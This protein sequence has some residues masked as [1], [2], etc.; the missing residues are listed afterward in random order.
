MAPDANNITSTKVGK[1][2]RRNLTLIAKV[3]Q[4]LSNGMLFGAKER[5]MTPL[6]SFLEKSWA[7]VDAFFA[8]L[9]NV[10]DLNEAME[11]DQFLLINTVGLTKC[12]TLKI[13]YN[14][15]MQIHGVIEQ[16]KSEIILPE[17][18]NDPIS[19]IM[20]MLG[21]PKEEVPRK[22]NASFSL[23]LDPLSLAKRNSLTG[24]VRFS[25]GPRLS[26][27]DREV[28]ARDRAVSRT[29]K[30]SGFGS[31]GSSKGIINSIKHSLCSIFE[32]ANLRSEDIRE[33]FNVEPGG[34]NKG[35]TLRMV[36]K[37]VADAAQGAEG[38]GIAIDINNVVNDLKK[39]QAVRGASTGEDPDSAVLS[40]VWLLHEQM[41]KASACA[42]KNSSRLKRALEDV[43]RQHQ[44][45]N[46]RI[47][48]WKYYLENVKAQA[49]GGAH[50]SDTH[51]KD[52]RKREKVVAGLFGKKEAPKDRVK[53]SYA[54]LSNANVISHSDIPTSA[55]SSVY[56]TFKE[57]KRFPGAFLVIAEARGLEIH[58]S[59]ILLE[60]LL[61]E[62]DRGSSIVHIGGIALDVNMLVHTLNKIFG[63]G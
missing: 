46:E 5:F 33:A 51:K 31:E 26:V 25:S 49:M 57:D 24:T 11:M 39:V 41:K 7:R 44:E 55:Q 19:N 14:E 22:E 43:E 62:Q 35:V 32:A 23:I 16:Y 34:A 15:I 21:S 47:D 4:N 29:N 28:N 59:T 48:T 56:V 3:V 12:R 6:N 61:A 13:S 10:E 18:S 2:Q 45:L 9:C 37:H 27:W 8:S 38:K 53:F 54:H 1:V 52:R 30:I 60:D 20:S 36:L 40:E 50:K 42:L 17:N 63:H 58:R